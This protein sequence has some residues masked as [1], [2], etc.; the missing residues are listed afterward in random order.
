MN[1]AICENKK[2][3]EGEPCIEVEENLRERY[4]DS[5]NEKLFRTASKVEAE[6]Y[7]KLTRLEEIIKFSLEMGYKNIGI[8]FCVGLSEEAEILY[9]IL[10]AH[11][12]VTSI[13]CKVC[14][15]NKEEFGLPKIRYDKFEAI[16]NPIGQAYLLN[17]Q[18]TDLN[19]ICGLCIGHDILF[20]KNS[21]A[22]VTTF[23]VKDRV[24]S[25]NPVGVL[26][27]NYYKRRLI[28]SSN[29]GK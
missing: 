26:Y 17:S 13:C 15:I 21:K 1:C 22:P 11:F 23:I 14:S 12:K 7:M 20:T 18:G 27:S 19:I 8:A 29:N 3:R 9:N 16:C 6:G 10:K 25:H 5:Y 2:C 4:L 24:L 28:Q